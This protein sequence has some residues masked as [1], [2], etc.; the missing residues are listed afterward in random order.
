MRFSSSR[1]GFSKSSASAIFENYSPRPEQGLDF[2]DEVGARVDAQARGADHD[3][4]VGQPDVEEH[5]D[6]ARVRL[7]RPLDAAH[8][9]ARLRIA[10]EPD[11]ARL[12]RP[13]GTGGAAG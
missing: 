12:R 2:R 3:L 1:S 5:G 7:A 4:V 6:P 8:D 9:R 11:P 10:A 13:A